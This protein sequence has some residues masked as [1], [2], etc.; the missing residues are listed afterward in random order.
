MLA[1]WVQTTVEDINQDQKE[2]VRLLEHEA[3]RLRAGIDSLEREIDRWVRGLGQGLS[4]CSGLNRRCS[5]TFRDFR[6]FLAP[7]YRKSSVKSA[8]S[9]AR[10]R[11]L[12]R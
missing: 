5:A 12:T 9:G 7:C 8:L 6:K 2:R 4:Q 1:P 10:Y 3:I 11:R